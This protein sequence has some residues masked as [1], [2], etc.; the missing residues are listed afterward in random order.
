VILSTYKDLALHFSFLHVYSHQDDNAPVETLTL[1]TR[2]NIEADRLAT[3][4]MVQ[5]QVRRPTVALFPS[6]KAQLLINEKTI[7]RKLPQAI[8]FAA[9]SIGIRAYLRERNE[10]T[11]PILD[12]VNWEAHGAGHSHHRPQRCYLIKLCH[13]HL[14]LGQKLHR[15]NAKYL[16]HKKPTTTTS[17]VQRLPE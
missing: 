13:R 17:N 9:G 3:E 1:E 7:T 11:E 5:D 4:Y 2:L 16:T 8:R 6:A 15:R 14:P 10:W 12:S